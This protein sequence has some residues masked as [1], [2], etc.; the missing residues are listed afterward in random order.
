M[1]VAQIPGWIMANRPSNII[2]EAADLSSLLRIFAA[3]HESSGGALSRSAR[4]VESIASDIFLPTLSRALPLQRSREFAH[5]G[6]SLPKVHR[7]TTLL[8]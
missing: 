8:C 6:K 1:C 7:E 2:L 4:R 3:V 5:H